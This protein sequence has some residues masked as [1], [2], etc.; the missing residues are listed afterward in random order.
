MIIISTYLFFLRQYFY[1]K[2]IKCH[3]SRKLIIF[4]Q[5]PIVQS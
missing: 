3:F 1:K 2:D 4:Q 5:M